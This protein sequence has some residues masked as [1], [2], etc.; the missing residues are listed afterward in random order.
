MDSRSHVL[1]RMRD[2]CRGVRWHL[3]A[4]RTLV[5]HALSRNMHSLRLPPMQTFAIVGHAFI[6]T[7]LLGAPSQIR[8][9][10][11]VVH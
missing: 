2:R 10:G 4:R 3:H 1:S 8:L 7:L 5:I 6:T 11:I 9:P